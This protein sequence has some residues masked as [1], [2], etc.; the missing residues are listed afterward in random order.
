MEERLLVLF[1]GDWIGIQGVLG[2]VCALNFHLYTECNKVIMS[3]MD[4]PFS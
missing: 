2:I 4:G 1:L 3:Y